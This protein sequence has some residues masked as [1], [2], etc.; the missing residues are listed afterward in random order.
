MLYFAE[1]RERVTRRVRRGAARARREMRSTVCGWSLPA[2]RFRRRWTTAPK[3]PALL[4]RRDL[5]ARRGELPQARRGRARA[6]SRV[7]RDDCV[8]A[9]RAGARA[10]RF[11]RRARRWKS[12]STTKSVKTARLVEV[13]QLV[14]DGAH[15]RHHAG[16]ARAH[17]PRDPGLLAS[18][19]AAGSSGTPSAPGTRTSRSARRS[20]ARASTQRACLAARA[21]GS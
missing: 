6:R 19:S 17:D 2:A 9:L 4:A 7:A 1:S 11:A 3:C 12:S 8:A 15:L 10:R 18:A 16:A 21:K 13:S 20:I 14:S 5:P